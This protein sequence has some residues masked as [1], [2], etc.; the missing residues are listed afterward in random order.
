MADI[1][2]K[3]MSSEAVAMTENLTLPQ[4]KIIGHLQKAKQVALSTGQFLIHYNE[5]LVRYIHE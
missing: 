5:P 4:F 1:R 3:W 2:Y